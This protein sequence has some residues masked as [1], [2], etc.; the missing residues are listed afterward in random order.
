MSA[1]RLDDCLSTRDGRLFMEECDVT[2]LAREFGTPLFLVSEDQ[3]V[4]NVRAYQRAFGSR[5]TEGPVDVLPALKSNWTLA[6]RRILS[7]EGAGADVYSPGELHAALTSGVNP[8]RISVNGGGKEEGLIRRCIEAGVRI[9]VEDLDEPDLIERVATEMGKTAKV[10]FR[11]KPNFPN[12]WRRTDFSLEVASIDFGI[13]VYKS[14]IPAQYLPEL[15]RKVLK[16]KNVELTGIHFHGGRHHPSAWYWDGLARVYARLVA[17]LCREWGGYK[18]QELDIGGGFASPRDPMNKQGLTGDVVMTWFLWPAQLLL[19][20]LPARHSYRLLSIIVNKGM[21]KDTHA[22]PAPTVD[23]YAEATVR[24]LHEEFRREGFDATGMRLQVEPGRGLYGNTGIHVAAVK[25][26]KR[27]TEPVKLNWALTDTTI[28]FIAGGQFEYNLHD[29]VVA[30][31]SDAPAVHVADIVGHSCYGD[32]IMPFVRV[33]DLEPGDLIAFLD[34]GAY[35][36][37]S[38]SNF[39]ALPRPATVL[40]T[41]NRAE[42]IKRAETIEDVFSRDLLPDHLHDY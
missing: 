8:E 22:K 29:F 25:K 11:V 1:T 28:F 33:P 2:A 35:Q 34:T 40:V 12:L 19:R 13:Q 5:W 6:T 30:N 41:G 27:Q 3:L 24:A 20:L 38:A 21:V 15:G 9:T 31:K 17:E 16:M 10:R 39:N 7:R 4:R 36:E 32:R 18:P 42:V 14:G 26:F 37:V 23:D